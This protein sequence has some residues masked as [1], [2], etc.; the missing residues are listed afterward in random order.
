L[1]RQIAEDLG[2][3]SHFLAKVLGTLSARGLLESLRGKTGGYRLARPAAEITLLE[4]VDPFDGVQGN[5]PC[6][7]RD[8]ACREETRC[9]IHT[10]WQHVHNTFFEFLETTTLADL[11]GSEDNLEHS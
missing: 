7:V 4:I 3:P 11:I 6:L 2:L 9:A 1:S 8:V 5:L 10:R